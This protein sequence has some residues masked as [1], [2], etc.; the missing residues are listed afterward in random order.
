VASTRVRAVLIAFLLIP[1]A[2]NNHGL[3]ILRHSNTATHCDKS[4][5]ARSYHTLRESTISA[6]L[7]S[8]W[9]LRKFSCLRIPTQKDIHLVD[10]KAPDAQDPHTDASGDSTLIRCIQFRGQ[11]D[12]L[13]SIMQLVV[14]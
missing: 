11:Q 8:L 7:I 5:I 12:F 9:G 4:S 6:G 10:G 2:V 1:F 13:H 14:L 3:T